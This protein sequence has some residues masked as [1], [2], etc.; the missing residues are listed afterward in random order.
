MPLK[1]LKTIGIDT[2]EDLE[3]ARKFYK[4]SFHV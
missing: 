1:K 4:E 3:N 2:P